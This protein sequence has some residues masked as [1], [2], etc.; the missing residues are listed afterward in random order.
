MNIKDV[1]QDAAKMGAVELAEDL[2]LTAGEISQRKARKIYGKYFDTLVESGRVWPIRQEVGRAGTKYFRVSDI[3]ACR[4][5]D[6][7]TATLIP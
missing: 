1:I 7:V 6:R 2:G 4:I 5:A 3:L